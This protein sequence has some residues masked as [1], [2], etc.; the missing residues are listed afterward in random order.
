MSPGIRWNGDMREVFW[1]VFYWGF[2]ALPIF[3][4][5]AQVLMLPAALIARL[6]WE[7]TQYPVIVQIVLSIARDSSRKRLHL[8]LHRV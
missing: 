4:I 8:D 2:L 6:L 7:P 5:T 1:G 3:L